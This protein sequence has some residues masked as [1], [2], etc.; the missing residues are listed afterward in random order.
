VSHWAVHG[1]RLSF[2]APAE[3]PSAVEQSSAEQ[4]GPALRDVLKRSAWLLYLA[5]MTAVTVAYLFG[6]PIVNSGP[7]FNMI[8]LSAVAAILVGTRLSGITRRLPWYLFALGQAFFV[9]G[10]V[11]A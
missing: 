9:T 5:T 2:R 1:R 3:D 6:P 7:V 10:D 4:G 11:L 8:G